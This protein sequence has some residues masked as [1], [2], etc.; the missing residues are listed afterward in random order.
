MTNISRI[1][2]VK[3]KKKFTIRFINFVNQK[4]LEFFLKKIIFLYLILI[5]VIFFLFPLV[6][7]TNTS[8]CHLF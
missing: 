2:Q 7:C 6:S 1:E 5:G 3:K 4:E 8:S